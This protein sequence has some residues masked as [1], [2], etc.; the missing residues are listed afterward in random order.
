[1]SRGIVPAS[2]DSRAAA[3]TSWCLATWYLDLDESSGSFGSGIIKRTNS[4]NES[5][6]FFDETN[7]LVALSRSSACSSGVSSCCF[8]D[9]NRLLQLGKSHCA[10]CSECVITTVCIRIISINISR[11]NAIN[12][13]LKL[14][15]H[16][17]ICSG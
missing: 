2:T 8:L 5:C 4:I 6:A 15:C 9:M 17:S 14:V 16:S 12:F 11:S 3:S 10:N 13:C 7:R 1:M